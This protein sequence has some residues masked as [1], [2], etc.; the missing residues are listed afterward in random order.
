MR[1]LLTA[2]DTQEGGPVPPQQPQIRRKAARLACFARG[3]NIL[4]LSDY[5]GSA[6]DA[7]QQAER[8][9]APEVRRKYRIGGCA[10]ADPTMVAIKIAPVAMRRCRCKLGCSCAA[11]IRSEFCKWL[12]VQRP[13]SRVHCSLGELQPQPLMTKGCNAMPTTTGTK[14]STGFNSLKWIVINVA[15]PLVL[16]IPVAWLASS[17]AIQ[18]EKSKGHALFDNVGFRYFQAIVALDKA[19]VDSAAQKSYVAV[20]TDIQRD[21]NQLRLNPFYGDVWEDN[22]EDL[23]KLQNFLTHDVV[24]ELPKARPG[25]LKHMCGLFS[26]TARWGSLVQAAG[27]EM[28]I[29]KAAKEICMHNKFSCR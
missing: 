4:I 3:S 12:S 20:L 14:K 25:T 10:S 8:P 11:P 21:L 7:G 5:E 26:C 22:A 17:W 9:N 2:H 19:G 29:A 28:T 13:S 6:L 24:N 16:A 15:L 23:A 1:C 18:N 27:P